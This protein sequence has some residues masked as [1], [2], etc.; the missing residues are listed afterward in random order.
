LGA[1]YPPEILLRSPYPV[2]L[3]LKAT[4]FTLSTRAAQ[5]TALGASL[6]RA[7][8]FPTLLTAACDAV[9][10]IAGPSRAFLRR[11]LSSEASPPGSAPSADGW[12]AGR[13]LA[14]LQRLH[15]APAPCHGD[16]PGLW[17][18]DFQP[19]SPR[20]C[21]AL[22]NAIG[23]AGRLALR[24]PGSCFHQP[25]DQRFHT[26]RSLF[27]DRGRML[28]TTF[29]SPATDSALTVSIPGSTFLA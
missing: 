22:N 20:A 27:P 4:A 2:A 5:R 24:L 12:L 28:A 17:P 14:R 6:S 7:V 26:R 25:P 23:N 16:G 1:S 15:F 21:S 18:A 3:S 8:C 9:G 11:N 29:R 19:C 13:V 10:L